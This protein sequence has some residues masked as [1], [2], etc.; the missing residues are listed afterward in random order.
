LAHAP[1]PP[2]CSQRI[3][4]LCTARLADAAALWSSGDLA[5][6]GLD[7]ASVR[8]LVTALF[9]DTLSRRSTLGGIK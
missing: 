7:A 3:L 5:A 9:E 4:T 8:G 1:L 6:A 2:S